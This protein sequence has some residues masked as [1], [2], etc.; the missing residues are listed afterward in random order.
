MSRRMMERKRK[1]KVLMKVCDF[2][3]VYLYFSFLFFFFG[4]NVLHSIILNTF[5]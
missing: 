5:D 2:I 4:F 3:P 1:G